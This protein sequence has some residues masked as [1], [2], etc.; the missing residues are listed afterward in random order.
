MNYYVYI[1]ESGQFNRTSEEYFQSIVGGFITNKSIDE[2]YSAL[3]KTILSVNKKYKSNFTSY[4]IHIAPLLH[5]EKTK[6]QE[7]KE[8]FQ[9]IPESIRKAFAESCKKTL[10]DSAI[11]L[12]SSK[13]SSFDF[14]KIDPQARYGNVLCAF[15]HEVINF[16]KSK[17]DVTSLKIFIAKRH[18]VCLPGGD[19]LLNKVKNTQDERIKVANFLK[20]YHDKMT[21]YITSWIKQALPKI[22]L[23]V[24]Y[25]SKY[26]VGYDFADIACY[27]LRKKDCHF[28]NDKLLSTEPNKHYASIYKETEINL[29]NEL[30][31]NKEYETAYRWADSQ[32]QKQNILNK[33]D[34]TDD[35]TKATALSVILNIGYELIDARTIESTALS[36]AIY[37]FKSFVEMTKTSKDENVKECFLSAANGLLVCANHS[38]SKQTQHKILA[39][40]YKIINE[41][42]HIPYFTKQEKILSVRNRAY[43]QHFNDYRFYEIIEN[44]ENV[45]K[46]REKQL[47]ENEMDCLTGE[48]LGTIGQAYA[49]LSKNNSEYA[50]T[51]EDYFKKSLFHF[52]K[53]HKYH[54]MSVNYL[55]TLR[56]YNNDILGAKEAFA[57]HAEIINEGSVAKW[58]SEIINSNEY[59]PG[60]TFNISVLLRLVVSQVSVANKSLES[61]ESFLKKCDIN[62][63]PY[64]LIYKWLGIAY[65]NN[66]EFINANKAFDRSIELSENLGFT[67]K[68]LA[69][70]AR[71]LKTICCHKKNDTISEQLEKA[72][73]IASITELTDVSVSFAK[74]IE[75]IGGREQ[76]LKD[77]KN[78]N[79]DVVAKWM[80][81]A[82]A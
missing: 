69:V 18:P 56:W 79:I 70:S 58:I 43:N 80:P 71:G 12:I 23:G 55:T 41:L 75:S 52:P 36:E 61:V 6:N 35:R 73:L 28:S 50:K 72:G 67:V 33:I 3:D 8:K 21:K 53:G 57:E 60:S 82:Y 16:I 19:E 65:L 40:Y 49:F 77:I 74:Y 25:S 14:G 34:K 13:N 4:D 30:I 66:K 9:R 20:E 47:P 7:E 64:E 68:T 15:M 63:H 27:Y 54:Q 46:A 29:F 26:K 42:S 59:H 17:N 62:Q 39:I 5:P 38:G 78:N 44:F 51:A 76:M 48:M 11:K 37:L 24:G 45:V 32:E 2:L 22:N 10:E 1:D 81:F 31:K